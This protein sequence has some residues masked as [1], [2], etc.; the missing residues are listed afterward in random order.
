LKNHINTYWSDGND[1]HSSTDPDI[2]ALANAVD[3]DVTNV[4][5]D[6]AQ[7]PSLISDVDKDYLR[8]VLIDAIIRT[9]D[10]LR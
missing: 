7:K 9:K 10:P 8:S 4:I 5:S 2:L 3:V 1:L 6:K